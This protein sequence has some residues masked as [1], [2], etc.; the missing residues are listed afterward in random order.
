MG[1]DQVVELGDQPHRRWRPGAGPR[2]LRQVEQLSPL[3]VTEGAQAGPQP[4][5][6][7]AE[8]GQ[9]RPGL[10]VGDRGRAER[11]EVARDQGPG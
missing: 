1:Q 2:R 6:H 8:P 10:H 7:L 3:L 5:G 9:P 11:A 4:V